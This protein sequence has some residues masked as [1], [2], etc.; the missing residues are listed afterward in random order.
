MLLLQ[1][2]DRVRM[3]FDESLCPAAYSEGLAMTSSAPYAFGV[4]PTWHG[5]RTELQF[6]NS[7]KM[8][9]SILLGALHLPVFSHVAAA[10]PSHTY[11][12][13]SLSSWDAQIPQ[14]GEVLVLGHVPRT[15]VAHPCM[16][17]MS[18]SLLC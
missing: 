4:D 13:L 1:V 7:V 6:L 11:A 8:K 10:C 18:R 12:C 17:R 16:S 5:T 14:I 15:P 9:I 3:K 2:N